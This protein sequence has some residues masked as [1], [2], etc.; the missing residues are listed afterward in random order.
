M[1]NPKR[2]LCG[3]L[4]L[5]LLALLVAPYGAAAQA[6]TKTYMVTVTN[7]NTGKQGLSPLVIATHPAGVH[8]W[9]IGPASF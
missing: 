7:I 8:A 4:A 1:L 3:M 9:Q 5:A 6:G 2:T